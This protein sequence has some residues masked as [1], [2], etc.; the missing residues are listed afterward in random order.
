MGR[1][2]RSNRPGAQPGLEY[3]LESLGAF[4]SSEDIPTEACDVG[5]STRSALRLVNFS[6]RWTMMFRQRLQ[7]SR[8]EDP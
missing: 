2:G 6:Q 1:V 5:N 7:E 3:W 8:N 4:Q